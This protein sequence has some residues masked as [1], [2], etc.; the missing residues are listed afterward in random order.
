MACEI[1]QVA[2]N[3]AGT[4]A[5]DCGRYTIIYAVGHDLDGRLADGVACGLSA[6][7]AGHNFFMNVRFIGVYSGPNLFFVRTQSGESQQLTQDFGP[8]P[9]NFTAEPSGDLTNKTCTQFSSDLDAGQPGLVC[10]SASAETTSC[11]L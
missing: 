2:P 9:P 7:D 11:Q 1:N 6:Q 10:T 8:H 4:G 3:I 5:I